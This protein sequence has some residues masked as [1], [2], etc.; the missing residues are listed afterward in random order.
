MQFPVSSTN[1]LPL[2]D[3]NWGGQGQGNSHVNIQELERFK[4]RSTSGFIILFNGPII[5]SSKR[6]KVTARSSAEAEIYATDECVKELLR[7]KHMCHDLDMQTIYMPGAPINV[8]N[9]NNACV[10]WSKT[11]TTKGLHHI[12]IRENAICE[13]MD[14][15]FIDVRHIAGKTNL[16]DMFTKEMK[17][18]SHFITM[19][20]LI[21]HDLATI[22]HKV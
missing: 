19:R 7:L 20:D 21:V 14:T 16:A 4:S 8:Y 1:L 18:T 11:H 2:T 12:T 9:D 6:Q 15:K 10:C 13:S 5:W 3:A 22:A 17:D